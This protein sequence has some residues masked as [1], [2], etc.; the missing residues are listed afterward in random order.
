[1][2]D[3]DPENPY[4]SVSDINIGSLLG[5][6]SEIGTTLPK[7]ELLSVNDLYVDTRYQRIIRSEGRK[8]IR[9]IVENFNWMHFQPL[10]VSPIG[11]RDGRDAYTIVDGQ[12]RAIAALNHPGVHRIPCAI[13]NLAPEEQAHVFAEI[14]SKIVKVNALEIFW[15]RYFSGD[16]DAIR[17]YDCVVGDA[18]LKIARYVPTITSNEIERSKWVGYVWNVTRVERAIKT[19]GLGYTSCALFFIHLWDMR[20]PA[21]L[22]SYTLDGVAR[23]LRLHSITD[24]AAIDALATKFAERWSY[25]D[26]A[27]Y[28]SELPKVRSE[29][30]F[31][32][33]ILTPTLTMG[34]GVVAA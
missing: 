34:G 9:H 28:C 1:M 10:L 15:A 5:E 26:V 21:A 22:N 19:F 4:L 20:E 14:N 24:S 12:H 32:D 13:V 7:V 2:A 25:E 31:F 11:K 16:E 8:N 23:F 17:V 3:V 27:K 29:N 18:D 6:P 30:A 33:D